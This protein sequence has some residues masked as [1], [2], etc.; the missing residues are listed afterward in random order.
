MIPMGNVPHPL[1]EGLHEIGEDT[2][3]T[4]VDPL[5]LVR[6]AGPRSHQMKMTPGSTLNALKVATAT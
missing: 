4:M 3:V 2:A 1:G 6:R 5:I